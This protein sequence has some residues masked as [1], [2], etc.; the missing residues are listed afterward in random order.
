MT[1]ASAGAEH[2]RA[3]SRGCPSRRRTR[4]ERTSRRRTRLGR[5]RSAVTVV[6]GVVG[7]VLL[8]ACGTSS[9][10]GA[11]AASLG[12][13]QR[14]PVPSSL[15]LV[16]A[17]GAPIS[18][19][20]LRGTVVVL[21]PFTTAGQATTPLLAAN[22]LAAERALDAAGLAKR[23]RFVEY[24]VDPALDTP[25]RLSAYAARAGIGWTLLTGS[26]AQVAAV[27]RFF[28]VYAGSAAAPAGAIPDWQTGRVPTTVVTHSAG[29]FL[30]GAGGDERFATSASP[31]SAPSTVP[32]RLRSMLGVDGL[33]ELNDPSVVGP[34]WTVRDLLDGIGWLLRRPVPNG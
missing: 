24:S 22:L 4:L 14:R 11:P 32:R 30:L 33:Q 31:A 12:I 3:A 18:F 27:N 8:G 10:P 21:A 26:L 16:T 29:Y 9:P 34:T 25:A 17:D 19:R 2:L 7:A 1:A 13:V 6:L 23:V 28:Y 5:R 15:R 20:Q